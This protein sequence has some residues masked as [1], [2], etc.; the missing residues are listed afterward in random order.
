MIKQRRGGQNIYICI[1]KAFSRRQ[2][3]CSQSENQD[4]RGNF[5]VIE[6]HKY[7]G[8]RYIGCG[9]T[10]IQNSVSIGLPV[11]LTTFGSSLLPRSWER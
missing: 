1:K 9:P 6:D 7:P 4:Y 3:A 11:G 5:R 8:T 2:K 10:R